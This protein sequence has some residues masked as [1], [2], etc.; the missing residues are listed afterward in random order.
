MNQIDQVTEVQECK[1][2]GG[3]SHPEFKEKG[4]ESLW[5]ISKK[6]FEKEYTGN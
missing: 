5:M 3:E 4:E 1:D 6:Y 2:K